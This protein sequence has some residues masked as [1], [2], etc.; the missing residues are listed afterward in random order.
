MSKSRIFPVVVSL[1]L[2]GP[3]VVAL[4]FGLA[5]EGTALGSDFG[6]GLGF[7]L[8]LVFPFGL[9]AAL[10]RAWLLSRGRG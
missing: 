7:T 9:L 4:A 6:H 2:A 10:V 8:G 1:A 5:F 3:V